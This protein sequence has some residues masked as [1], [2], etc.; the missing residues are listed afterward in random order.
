MKFV[1]SPNSYDTFILLLILVLIFLKG[2]LDAQIMR[3][4]LCKQ[5]VWLVNIVR[6][7]VLTNQTDCLLKNVCKNLCV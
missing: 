4:F 5:S 1:A 3:K 6:S 7:I 2:F